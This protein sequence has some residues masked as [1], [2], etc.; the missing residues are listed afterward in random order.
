MHHRFHHV[1]KVSSRSHHRQLATNIVVQHG[2]LNVDTFVGAS[3]LGLT[4]GAA[5]RGNGTAQRVFNRGFFVGDFCFQSAIAQHRKRH[6]EQF[7][8]LFDARFG[9]VH[10][11]NPFD[12]KGCRIRFTTKTIGDGNGVAF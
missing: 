6:R 10:G 9:F 12:H 2:S 4:S 8:H 11:R 3:F 1:S 7:K 5:G